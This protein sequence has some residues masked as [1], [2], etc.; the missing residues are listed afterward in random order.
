MAKVINH[1]TT[2]RFICDHLWNEV[3][4]QIDL[5]KKSDRAERLKKSIV[6]VVPSVSIILACSFTERI[7]FELK[8]N[9]PDSLKPTNSNIPEV[10][11]LREWQ[12]YFNLDCTWQGWN[13][14]ANFFRLRHCALK[15][16]YDI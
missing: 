3:Y 8:K 12:R 15:K 5:E 14:F 2:I 11:G 13:E 1:S 9:I 7:V 6:P 4:R 16:T 10:G